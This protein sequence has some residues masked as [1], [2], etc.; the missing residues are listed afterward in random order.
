[1]KQPDS[2]PTIALIPPSGC[3]AGYFRKLRRALGGRVNAVAVELPGHGRRYL[4]PCLTDAGLATADVAARLPEHVDAVYGESLGAYIGLAVVAATTA[5]RQPL[6]LAAS[7]LPPA[8][9]PGIDTAQVNSLESAVAAFEALG[10]RIPDDLLRKPD[11]ARSAFPLIRDDLL[12]SHSYL[13]VC[14]A[15]SITSDI[16][17][18]V[19][20]DDASCAP[21]VDGWAAHTTGSCEIVRVPG[22]HLLSSENPE[23]VATVILQALGLD[24]R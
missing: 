17:V 8:E 4:E 14:R 12:L 18:A 16:R 7:N 3:G 6:L 11:V 2:G 1:V 21:G 10:A 15:A 9:H 20:S 19:G 23:G 24:G 13:A 5:A 22:G